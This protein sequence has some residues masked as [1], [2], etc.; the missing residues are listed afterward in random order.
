MTHIYVTEDCDVQ[1][2]NYK[3]AL[4]KPTY[5]VFTECI[6]LC[7]VGENFSN[8]KKTTITLLQTYQYRS[9]SELRIR[10]ILWKNS[11]G[12]TVLENTLKEVSIKLGK[13]CIS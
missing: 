9:N 1:I 10:E 6:N 4:L 13:P 3:C 5:R 7:D 11:L 12:E 8:E 2:P